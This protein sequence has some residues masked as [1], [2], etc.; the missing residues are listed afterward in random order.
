MHER[1][2]PHHLLLT[3]EGRAVQHGW[4][5]NEAVARDKCRRWIG[6]VGTMATP[7]RHPH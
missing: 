7:A 1:R 2:R 6:S 5:P 3:S 4:W